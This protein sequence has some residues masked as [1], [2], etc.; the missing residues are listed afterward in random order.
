MVAVD[1]PASPENWAPLIAYIQAGGCVMMSFWDWDAD[2]ALS[3]AFDV[4]VANSII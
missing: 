4:Q 1:A 3:A 2:L